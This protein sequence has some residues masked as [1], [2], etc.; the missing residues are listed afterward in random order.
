M[1][2]HRCEV[3]FKYIFY[4]S[5]RF[6]VFIFGLFSFAGSL[7]VAE[8]VFEAYFEF[9]LADVIGREV[10]LAGA[11]LNSG[12]DEIQQLTHPVNRCERAQVFGAIVDFSSREKYPWKIF[13]FENHEGVRLVIFQV[14]VEAGLKLLDER[15]L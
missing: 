3:S 14:D 6:P 12:A 4:L 8:V 7:A 15:I 10:K 2:D 9:A 5:Q 1:V 13:I 11:Q